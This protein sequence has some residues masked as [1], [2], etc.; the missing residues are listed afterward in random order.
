[1]NG[2]SVDPNEIVSE[3][4]DKIFE[5]MRELQVRIFSLILALLLTYTNKIN[6]FRI[7]CLLILAS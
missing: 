5:S 6:Y 3:Y 2:Y 4:K 7:K 1:M